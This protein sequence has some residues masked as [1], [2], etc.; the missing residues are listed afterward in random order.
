[1]GARGME[2]REQA[3]GRFPHETALADRIGTL[4]CSVTELAGA[5]CAPAKHLGNMLTPQCPVTL[6]HKLIQRVT[7]TSILPWPQPRECLPSLFRF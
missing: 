7:L 3:N 1:M 6:Q 2:L 5:L 4:F